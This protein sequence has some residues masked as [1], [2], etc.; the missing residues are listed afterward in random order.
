M[1]GRTGR[2]LRL[3]YTLA[4]LWLGTLATV[5]AQTSPPHRTLTVG[6]DFNFPPFYGVCQPLLPIIHSFL[7][8]KRLS[9]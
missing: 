2:P 6:G 8:L 5:R 1:I 7:C 4:A 9:G 3:L